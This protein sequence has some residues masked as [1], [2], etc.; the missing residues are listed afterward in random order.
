MIALAWEWCSSLRDGMIS[1]LRSLVGIEKVLYCGETPP[2]HQWIAGHC[3]WIQAIWRPKIAKTQSIGRTATHWPL[4]F[5]RVPTSVQH[6]R[7]LRKKVGAHGMTT[8]VLLG[9]NQVIKETVEYIEKTG[10]FK[11]V[12]TSDQISYCLDHTVFETS[13]RYHYIN[14]WGWTLGEPNKQLLSEVIRCDEAETPRNRRWEGLM[15]PVRNYRRKDSFLRI[16]MWI[17]PF[18]LVICPYVTFFS[19]SLSLTR[20][21]L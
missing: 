4:S 6:H 1:S 11:L 12:R 17:F 15:E 20:Y 7:H 8:S 16:T 10:R 2:K 5:Q 9:D 19:V 13:T 21:Q 18:K 3:H 14:G